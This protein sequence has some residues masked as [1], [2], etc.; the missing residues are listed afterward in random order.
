MAGEA[1][2]VARRELRAEVMGSQITWG[3]WVPRRG[4]QEGC[5]V[6]FLQL[7]QG[8]GGQGKSRETTE[9][10]AVTGTRERHQRGRNGREEKRSDWECFS[11]MSCRTRTGV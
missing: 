6:I 9:V 7:L 10:V 2:E 5:E 4:P 11:G 3:V 8:V 1:S